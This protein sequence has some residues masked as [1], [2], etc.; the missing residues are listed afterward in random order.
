MCLCC[1]KALCVK[2]VFTIL[3][4]VVLVSCLTCAFDVYEQSLMFQSSKYENALPITGPGCHTEATIKTFMFRI[5]IG[6]GYYNEV[7]KCFSS[8]E[9]LTE[10]FF[11]YKNGESTS[12]YINTNENGAFSMKKVPVTCV[13]TEYVNENDGNATVFA[14]S[15][16][17]SWGGLAVGLLLIFCIW[18]CC[19]DWCRCCCCKPKDKKEHVN[20]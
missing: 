4:V 1:C 7:S 19:S 15:A 12:V 10:T 2:L 13:S 17:C 8:T 3:L 6:S 9:T 11:N 5:P 20:V 16:V 14:V 18:F